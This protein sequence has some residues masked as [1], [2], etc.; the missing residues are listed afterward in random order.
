MA[1]SAF[2]INAN[3]QVGIQTSNPQGVFNIDAARDNPATGVPTGA[4]Q[5]NDI[6]VTATGSMGV[7]TTAPA[8]KVDIVGTT[9]GIKN[10][11]ASGSWDNLWFNVT[12][13]IPSINASGA[14]SGLQ[15]NVGSNSVGTYGDGQTL[16]TVATMLSTGNMG[17]G[18]TNPLTK[19]HVEGAEVRLTNAASRWGLDPEGTSPTSQFSIID[20]TNSVRRLVLL[21]NGNAFMGGALGTNGGN[22]TISS[23][24]GSVGIGNNGSPTNTLDVNGTTRVRTMTQVAGSNAVTPVYSDA[25]GVLSKASVSLT[26]GSVISN[27]VSVASGATNTFITAGMVDNAIYKAVVTSGDAC[28]YAIVAEYYVFNI[29]ANS[30]FSIRGIS[31][32]ISNSTNNTK[33]PTFNEIDKNTTATSWTGKPT[34]ADTGNST[35]LNFTLIMP[36]GSQINVKNDGNITRSYTIVLTRLT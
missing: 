11:S 15:F 13:S 33:G 17:V 19:F 7:G 4:Q 25:N 24:G 34:C 18:T 29:A 12:P 22:A 2:A 35:A 26:Y 10:S 28:G 3:A 6:A 32:L 5:A 27:T 14:E 9:F 23:V 31:G 16:T 20:R 8:A 36:S 30:N 1:I 21:E